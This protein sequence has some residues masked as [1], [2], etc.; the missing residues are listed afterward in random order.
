V[1]R[2][3]AVV[4]EYRCAGVVELCNGCRRGT[5][6][7]GSRSSKAAVQAYSCSTVLVA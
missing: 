3:T 7:Q 2:D 6:D 5:G 1:Y 4:Q